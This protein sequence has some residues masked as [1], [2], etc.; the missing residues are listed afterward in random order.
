MEGINGR[1]HNIAELWQETFSFLLNDPT[2]HPAGEP[3]HW[4]S[5]G[6]H[7]KVGVSDVVEAVREANGSVSPGHD[8]LTLQHIT[9]AIQLSS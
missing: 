8:G 9:L 2:H 6:L 1:R 5:E 4:H 7:C 3:I